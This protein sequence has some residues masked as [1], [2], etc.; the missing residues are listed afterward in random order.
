MDPVIEVYGYAL[1]LKLTNVTNNIY[2][3]ITNDLDDSAKT[4]HDTDIGQD[5]FITWFES[6]NNLMR[7]YS[8]KV[9]SN[10]EGCTSELYR[11]FT[12]ELPKFNPCVQYIECQKDFA[13][14]IEMCQPFI[15]SNKKTN[16]EIREYKKQIKEAYEKYE[17][18]EAKK[19]EE[20][21]NE[22]NVTYDNVVDK[23]TIMFQLLSLV[24]Q[25]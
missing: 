11:E 7:T 9:Y 20:K 25:Y 22:D 18:S 3:V 6:E 23:A 16:D 15:F 21:A 17:K 1:K 4:F 24:V 5:G 12:V 10:H 13:K 19:N 2:V 14:D 8:V